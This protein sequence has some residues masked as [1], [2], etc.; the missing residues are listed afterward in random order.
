[1]TSMKTMIILLLLA[2]C[3]FGGLLF[4]DSEQ[5]L[6]EKFHKAYELT[7]KAELQPALKIYQD[8]ISQ[9]PYDPDLL[10]N[11]GTANLMAGKLGPAV[12][13][14]ERAILIDPDCES[15]LYNLERAREQQQD[16]VIAKAGKDGQDGVS[17]DRFMAG[18]NQDRLAIGF[19]VFH[20][21]LLLI[22][23]LRRF[24]NIERIRFGLTLVLI[25]L[26]AADLVAGGLLALKTYGYE[27]EQYGV[28][29]SQEIAVRKGPNMNF[30]KAFEVHEGIKVRLG[31][32]VEDWRQIWLS[33]GLNGYLLEKDIGEI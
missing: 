6:Q 10:Y 11:A 16:Q 3:L 4:A 22:F 1:M 21:S 25:L 31:E 5:A 20:L 17:L 23:I 33:N 19:L 13:Y 15:C 32:K 27:S 29:L 8:L 26:L 24:I 28:V 12:M 18:I 30:P 7:V 14:L 2:P 9:V